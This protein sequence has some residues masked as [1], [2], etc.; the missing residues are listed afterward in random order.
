M[1]KKT[2]FNPINLK[3]CPYCGTMNPTGYTICQ[4]CRTKFS[5]VTNSSRIYN[6]NGR[7][8]RFVEVVV[9]WFRPKYDELITYLY[10]LTSILVLVSYPDFRKIITYFFKELLLSPWENIWLWILVLYIISGFTLS[11]IHAFSRRKKSLRVKYLMAVFALFVNG[12]AGIASGVEL[13]SKERPILLILPI[14]NFL[15]GGIYLYQIG[16]ANTVEITDENVSIFTVTVASISLLL[17]Y[18][19]A[20]HLLDF[21]WEE[22]FSICILFSSLIASARYLSLFKRKY[23]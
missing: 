4:K 11:L 19:I 18:L 13:I 20:Y 3:P 22:T 1:N 15:M 23:Y 12:S 21:S 17:A 14:L 2:N 5:L 10:A 8:F 7:L 16:M 9:G 6:K